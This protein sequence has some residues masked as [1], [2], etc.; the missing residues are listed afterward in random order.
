MISRVIH[1]KILGYLP[2]KNVPEDFWNHRGGGSAGMKAYTDEN[3]CVKSPGEDTAA[4]NRL[5]MTCSGLNQGE[6]VLHDLDVW[7]LQGCRVNGPDD[8]M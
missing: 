3:K 6:L 7:D 2:P 5:L 4:Q 8:Q 1:T